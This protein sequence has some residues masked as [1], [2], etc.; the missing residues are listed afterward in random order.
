[1]RAGLL[2]QK[3]TIQQVTDSATTASAGGSKSWA[4]FA[5][6]WARIEALRG[7]EFYQA[8]VVQTD[9]SHKVT[10]RYLAGVTAKMRIAYGSRTLEIVSVLDDTARRTFLTLMCVERVNS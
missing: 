7:A 10:I 6:V 4:T 3:V 1:M 8:Q 2:D 5:T 9:L